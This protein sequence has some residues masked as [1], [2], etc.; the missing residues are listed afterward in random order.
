[1]KALIVLAFASLVTFQS[2]RAIDI[3]TSVVAGVV[4]AQYAG[5]AAG[6]AV[7]SVLA[8]AA[9][10]TRSGGGK[11]A[12]AKAALNDA[13][14]FYLTGNLSVALENSI[15]SIQDLDDSIS[16]EEAVDMIVEAIAE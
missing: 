12:V 7:S 16:D 3:T 14:E 10:V 4:V 13:Q 15:R 9:T 5:T 2:A 8:G 6:V 11:E 1:M